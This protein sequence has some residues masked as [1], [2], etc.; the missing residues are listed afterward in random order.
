[1]LG[2]TRGSSMLEQQSLDEFYD[3]A[4]KSDE[5]IKLNEALDRLLKNSDFN[6]V[7]VKGYLTELALKLVKDKG[8]AYLGADEINI[9]RGLIGISKL[10]HHLDSIRTNAEIAIKTRD[11]AYTAIHELTKGNE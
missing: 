8:T 6:L 10:Q 7:I 9:D 11:D 3:L 4:N 5:D 2:D 1:M